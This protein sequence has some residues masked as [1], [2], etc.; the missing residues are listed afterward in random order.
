MTHARWL[1]ARWSARSAAPRRP[2]TA[3]VA[4]SDCSARVRAEHRA[5]AGYQAT[6]QPARPEPWAAAAGAARRWAP[7]LA[8]RLVAWGPGHRAARRAAAARWLAR[9]RSRKSAPPQ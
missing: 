5:M 6:A 7:V 3:T 4:G 1:R 2:Q 8:A 9:T